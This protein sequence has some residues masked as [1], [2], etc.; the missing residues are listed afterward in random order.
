ML[1][2]TEVYVLDRNSEHLGVPQREL[3]E[4]AGRGVAESL[5]KEFD[6]K[7]KYVLILAGTGNNGGD[8]FVAA[9]YLKKQCKTVVGLVRSKKEVRKGLAS[10]NLEK[11]KSAGVKVLSPEANIDRELKSADIIVDAMLGVGIKKDVKEP[12]SYL[13]KKLN[14]MKKN[15][16][17]VDVPSGFGSNIAIKPSMTVTFHDLK[18][19]MNT[20]NSGKIKVVDI[21]IPK[22]AELYVGPGEFIYY[23]IP[24]DG[25]HKGDNGKVLVIGGGPYTGAPALAAMGAF[26]TGA[27]LVMLAVPKSCY[28]VVASFSPN[29]I[30]QPLEGDR[31]EPSSVKG[32]LDLVNYFD[33]VLIGPGAGDDIETTG[34]MQKFIKACN[35]PMVIDADAIK[36]VAKSPDILKRKDGIITPH[37]G[38]FE[39]LQGSALPKTDEEQAKKVFGFAKKTGFTVILKG[40]VDV[41]SNGS[42]TKYNKTGNAAMSV[43]GTGDVLAG[44]CAALMAKGMV[45]FDAARLATLINGWA[46]DLA[47]KRKSYGLTATDVIDEIPNVLKNHLG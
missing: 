42:W 47:F 19:G 15:I 2:F 9:R 1:S 17:S 18:E 44:I 6:L 27:D 35:T 21:G 26:R 16:V 32:L 40:H 38:E 10:D 20:K 5:L 23:P 39:L 7:G 11:L 3:M 13:I 28:Q 8:G 30:V 43:G 37:K 34:M 41:I 25:S 36:S 22:E 14:H 46:G 45:S 33:S 24:L 29:F 12:Y 4:N 31:L